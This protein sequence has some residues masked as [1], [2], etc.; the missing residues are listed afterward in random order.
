MVELAGSGLV[1][2]LA[3]GEAEGGADEDPAPIAL[4][5]EERAGGIVVRRRGRARGARAVAEGAE[6]GSDGEHDQQVAGHEAWTSSPLQQHSRLI[7]PRSAPSA[8]GKDRRR[9]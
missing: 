1:G 4:R 5:A 9:E 2:T 6:Q 3:V 8:M 7:L